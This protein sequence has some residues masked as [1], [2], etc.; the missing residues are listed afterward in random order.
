M[1]VFLDKIDVLE[2]MSHVGIAIEQFD[3]LEHLFEHL[4]IHIEDLS[5]LL[6]EDIAKA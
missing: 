1:L 3:D 5:G 6:K 2:A 4:G